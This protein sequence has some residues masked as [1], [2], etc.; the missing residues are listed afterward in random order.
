MQIVS[1][2]VDIKS[3]YKGDMKKAKR[4][5]WV[6]YCRVNDASKL[7][8][9]LSKDPKTLGHIQKQ[10]GTCTES[11]FE[12]LNLLP[13]IFPKRYRCFKLSPCE[14]SGINSIFLKKYY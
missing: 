2:K 12:T 13:N 6:A 3:K 10:D 11:G 9:V 7:K 1:S 14:Y 8:R 4:T 5:S